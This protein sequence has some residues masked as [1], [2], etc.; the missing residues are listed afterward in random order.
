MDKKNEMIISDDKNLPTLPFAKYQGVLKL[1]NNEVDC[2]V[3]DSKQRLISMR[4]VVK[5][6]ADVDGGGLA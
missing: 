3:S 6:I 2:Y 1:G 5:A 4:T